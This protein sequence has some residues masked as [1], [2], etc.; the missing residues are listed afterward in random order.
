M[1][2]FV[3]SGMFE[4]TLFQ[5]RPKYVVHRM[6]LD[7]MAHVPGLI[8]TL[9]LTW[10]DVGRKR[11]EGNINAINPNSPIASIPHSLHAVPTFLSF[12]L[13]PHPL[14][15]CTSQTE[16]NIQAVPPQLSE[17]SCGNKFSAWKKIDRALSPSIAHSLGQHV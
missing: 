3:A 14:Y 16:V 2:L 8:I 11:Q 5:N 1:L 9:R 17:H 12:P 15:P 4:A 6:V 10:V 7:F 13:V